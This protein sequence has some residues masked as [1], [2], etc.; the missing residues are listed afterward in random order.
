[1]SDN[2]VE[3]LTALKERALR[4]S[5]EN[6]RDFYDSY[7]D[8]SAIAILPFGRIDKSGVLDAMTGTKAPFSA[9]R[10]ENTL[11]VPLGEEAA[12]VTYDAVYERDGAEQVVVAT[13]VYRK[14]PDG[15]KGVL[16][17]QTPISR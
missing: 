16:Y 5:A 4:A 11:I 13:T 7:L 17:Q 6:D 12:V 15:W 10:V 3:E 9:T 1:M 2:I 8:D 14:N